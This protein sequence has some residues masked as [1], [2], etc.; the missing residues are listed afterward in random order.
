M[1]ERKTKILLA[2][3]H[4]IVRMGVAA[5]ISFEHDLAVV[6][7]A[8]DGQ[9]AVRMADELLPDVVVMD[10]MMPR[11]S[12][13]E[14]TSAIIKAHPS[15]GIL[16]LTSFI[17]S[18][19]LVAAIR[20][21]ARGALPKTASQGEII[22]AIRRIAAGQKVLSPSLQRDMAMSR[23]APELTTRQ[24]EVLRLSA[25]GFTT[26]DIADILGVSPNSVKDHFK[27]IFRRL[28]ASSRSEAVAMALNNG[29]LEPL[30]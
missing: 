21:G 3:D 29:L 24:M 13:T 28:G 8:A 5:A 30:A 2:D 16:I 4:V 26:Q 11:L 27:L 15:I 20:A 6:G 12:G 22:A 23:L 25:R 18:T 9:E 19:D 7:E 17:A 14:A 1:M 10:L